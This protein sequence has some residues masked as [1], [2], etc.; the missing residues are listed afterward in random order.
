MTTLTDDE[1]RAV[2]HRAILQVPMRFDPTDVEPDEDLWFALDLD[3]MDQ[4]NVM[5][6]IRDQA[7]IDVPEVDYPK[8]VTTTGS[9]A[10]LISV[11]AG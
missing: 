10:Y 3:S 5:V 8:M 9:V 1:A 11:S 2:L 6:A 7:G 4:L